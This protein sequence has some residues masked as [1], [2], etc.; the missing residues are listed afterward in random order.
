MKCKLCKRNSPIRNSIFCDKC[1][2]AQFQIETILS[3][4]LNNESPPQWVTDGL[5]EIAS[6]AYIGHPHGSGYFNTANEIVEIF[7]IERAETISIDELSEI[8]YTNLPTNTVLN[9]LKHALI[10][11]YDTKQIFPGPISKKLLKIRWDGYEMGSQE[12]KMKIKEIHGI[13]SVSLTKSLLIANR[14]KP[15]RALGLLK[16]MSKIILDSSASEKISP[17]ITDYDMD[18]ALNKLPTRQQNKIKRQIS[19]LSDGETKIITDK[20]IEGHMPLKSSVLV[21][22]EN[23]RE[24]YRERERTE[25][26]YTISQQTSLLH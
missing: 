6:W 24:R 3:L 13:I 16:L 7:A 22:L 14:I 25:R 23:M 17:F 9:I 20:D 8:N 2:L 21:Y 4:Y 26:G 18:I 19:G 11:D 1:D 10:I 5:I 12:V 15:Q